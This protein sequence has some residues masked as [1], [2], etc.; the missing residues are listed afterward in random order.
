[1]DADLAVLA[2]AG[3]WSDPRAAVILAELLRERQRR[4]AR[5]YFDW[6]RIAPLDD[7]TLDARGRLGFRDLAVENGVAVPGDARYR[8]RMSL[9]SWEA[10]TPGAALPTGADPVVVEVAVSHDRGV[11]WSPPVPIG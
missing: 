4:I 6:H 10:T 9:G 3:E 11:T 8:R 7:F 2:R 1:S 5:V